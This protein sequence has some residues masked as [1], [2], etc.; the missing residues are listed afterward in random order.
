MKNRLETLERLARG[1]EEE[2]SFSSLE[3]VET[4]GQTKQ[5]RTLCSPVNKST[6]NASPDIATYGQSRSSDWVETANSIISLDDLRS[7]A[8]GDS[9]DSI[10]EVLQFPSEIFSNPVENDIS[11][12][13]DDTE[14]GPWDS[15]QTVYTPFEA[16]NMPASGLA[17]DSL[18]ELYMTDSLSNWLEPPFASIDSSTGESHQ[19]NP[20]VATQPNP[21]ASCM[22]PLDPH[23]LASEVRVSSSSLQL[24]EGLEA[25]KYTTPNNAGGR[26]LASD[27]IR[28]LRLDD[29]PEY[30][31]L[32]KTA[33]AR[34]HNIRDVLLT[35]LATLDN[36]RDTEQTSS[37]ELTTRLP[38]L[39]KNTLTLVRTS[40]L[41]ACLSIADTMIA[42]GMSIPALY[43]KTSPSPF[44]RPQ[45]PDAHALDAILA[46]YTSKIKI[47]LRPTASQITCLHHPW[48]DL[49]PFPTLRERIIIM[50]S[51][52]PPIIDLIEFKNDV[53]LNNGL[54][55]WHTSGKK[56][57]GQPW[58]M[59]SW[60]AEPW[61]LRKWW[62]LL[63]GEDAEVWEQTKWWREIR[64][65]KDVKLQWSS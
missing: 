47:H 25:S 10:S 28:Q 6:S 65:E 41:Q 61:F 53:F 31:C 9:E 11:W 60:E 5:T 17:G 37:P 51:T 3:A 36:N 55:C 15:S 33:I 42:I 27:I 2:R 52:N 16:C 14:R 32:V 49:I 48:L 19:H 57:S 24:Y 40:T 38:D 8:C 58:D 12:A 22:T 43:D 50:S 26:Q 29:T 64:G 39:H 44:Y 20:V 45:A 18:P 63:G 62:T 7:R 46:T 21:T 35:G 13:H 34:G 54:F 4:P 23:H 56:G 30:Q 59:R 1:N